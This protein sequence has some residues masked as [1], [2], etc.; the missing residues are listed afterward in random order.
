M[1][2][3]EKGLMDVWCRAGFEKEGEGGEEVGRRG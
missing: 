1:G 2:A 3:G